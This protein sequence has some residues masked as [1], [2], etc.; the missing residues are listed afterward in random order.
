MNRAIL[1]FFF[2]AWIID[3]PIIGIGNLKKKIK[4]SMRTNLNLRLLF[5]NE[6]MKLI[7]RYVII[8]SLFFCLYIII[9]YKNRLFPSFIFGKFYLLSTDKNFTVKLKQSQYYYQ[10]KTNPNIILYDV[11][12]DNPW[13]FQ[14]PFTKYKESDISDVRICIYDP[15]HDEHISGQLND[16]GKWEP[17]VVRSFLRLLRTIPNTHV[18]DVGSNIGLYTLL[19]TQLDRQVLSIEPLY[20]SLIRLHKSIQLNNVEHL[21]TVIANAIGNKHE[22][23]QLN[24]VD[25]NIGGS[26]LSILDDMKVNAVQEREIVPKIL[27]DVDTIVLDDLVDIYPSY[28]KRAILKLDIEGFEAYA[29]QNATI[30]FNRTEIPAVYMEFGKLIELKYSSGM[31]EAIK[32]MIDFLR[33]RNYEPYE[34]ND[35]NHLLFDNWESWPWDIVFKRCD[36]CR[37][38]GLDKAVGLTE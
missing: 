21:V 36:L 8:F 1:D 25:K 18:I 23:L 13:K 32:H 30:L 37:C 3:S 19:A 15:Q 27:A 26:Y 33:I 17:V 12:Q 14:C 9:V 2:D 11:K 24:I 20:D 7:K 31:M 29:F 6:M 35:L 38:P 34:V 28:F 5:V 22:K 16:Y 10:S 4:Y